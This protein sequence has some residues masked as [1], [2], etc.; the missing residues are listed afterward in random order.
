MNIYFSALVLVAGALL[1]SSLAPHLSVIG[2]KPGIVLTL[3]VSWSAIRGASEGVTWG[4]IGGL[5]L[6]LLSG[7]PV[8]LSALTLMMVGF[9]TN[10]GETNLF[11][12]SLVLPLFA[13]FVASVLSDAVQ[14]VLL[15][16]LGWNLPWWEAMASVAV[17]AAIL[18]AV[19]MPI[20][21]LPLPWLNR[22]ARTEGELSW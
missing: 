12:S 15:Q 1:Q 2:V 6:D 18:N 7:A 21:Y 8:G 19:I 5:A 11:K 4:F 16:G 3:V 9:L 10:L 17:P 13:V 22:R 20:I 14:L